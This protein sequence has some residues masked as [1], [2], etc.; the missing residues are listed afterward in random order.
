MSE[1][2]VGIFAVFIGALLCFS[3]AN[4]MKILLPIMGF[5]LGFSAGAGMISAISG[6]HFLG[7]LFGWAVGLF[8]G[9][10]FAVLSYFFYAF[11]VVLVFAGLGFALTSGLLALLHMDWNWLVII[12]GTLV[13]IVFGLVALV[14]NMP[15][16]VLVLTTAFLG[17]AVIIYGLMLVFKTAELGDFSSGLVM[18][19]IHDNLGLYILWVAAAIGGSVSQIKVIGEQAKAMQAY[20]ESSKDFN[21]F[22]NKATKAK[23]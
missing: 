23:K 10:L 1:I 19:R 6:E 11:A 12:L 8:V 5:F 15:I 17:A 4:I 7:T 2:L 14:T 13:A 16:L 3:G 22:L 20:W 21:D 18:D 9:L